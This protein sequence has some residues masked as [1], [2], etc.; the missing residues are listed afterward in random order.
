MGRYVARGYWAEGYVQEEPESDFIWMYHLRSTS[1]P[2]SGR[3]MELG[4]SY[5]F[6]SEPDGPDQR[7]LT[8]YFDTMFHFV[9]S[10]GVPDKTISPE[11]NIMALEDFYT[12]HRLWKTFTYLHPVYGLLNVK[13]GKPLEVPKGIPG[14]NGSVEPFTIDL[15]E[16]P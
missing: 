4:G 10:S 8:L 7:T 6:A 16:M 2:E 3:R 5:V 15:I 13:F 1:Y 11:L 9:N 12:L 14:G